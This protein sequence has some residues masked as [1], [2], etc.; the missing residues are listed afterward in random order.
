MLA[1]SLAE[2]MR[3][4]HHNIFIIR[5]QQFDGCVQRFN[6]EGFCIGR[7]VGAAIN[8]RPLFVLFN[9]GMEQVS[10]YVVSDVAG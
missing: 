3:Q 5:P 8:S 7:V 10:I 2:I 4:I 1:A 9:N 6:R